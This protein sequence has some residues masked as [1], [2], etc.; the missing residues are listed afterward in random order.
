M[1][2]LI[3]SG[4]Y[5]TANFKMSSYKSRQIRFLIRCLLATQTKAFENAYSWNL[6]KTP[7][8]APNKTMNGKKF[9]DC[10]VACQ[11]QNH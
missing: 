7:T 4:S 5:F 2:V 8:F 10:R 11:G 1:A 6:K 3:L 9:S